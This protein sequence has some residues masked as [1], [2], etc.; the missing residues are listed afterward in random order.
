MKLNL[1]RLNS[2]QVTLKAIQ[3]IDE[4]L[5]WYREDKPG[6]AYVKVQNPYDGSAV[7]AQFDRDEFREF[8][9]ERKQKLIRHLEERFEGFE[10]DPKADWTGDEK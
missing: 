3:D 5:E 4:A 6:P 1:A 10:Y 7:H 9:N 8:M 2:I